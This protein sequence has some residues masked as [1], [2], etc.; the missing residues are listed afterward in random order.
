MKKKAMGGA[1]AWPLAFMGIVLFMFLH[2][3]LTLAFFTKTEITGN[4]PV[5][6][7]GSS[8]DLVSNSKF[9]SFLGTEIF[10]NGKNQ[11]IIE[12][13]RVTWEP[14]SNIK[15]KKGQS[16]TEVFN[17]KTLAS[18]VQNPTTD[19]KYLMTVKYGFTE[20]DYYELYDI[21][22][23]INEG[24]FVDK[25]IN[26]L[27]KLCDIDKI[28]KYYLETPYGVITRDGMKK[29]DSRIDDLFDESGQSDS[30]YT[31]FISH[32]TNYKGENIEIRF[33]MLK[34]CQL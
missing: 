22:K 16:L 12:V 34:A 32:K 25:I 5:T 10:V 2:V 15:N 30:E 17:F 13:L 7:E 8:V 11:K 29:K 4:V 31:P 27:N 19:F 20:D 28:D 1:V 26:E 6:F 3:S 21:N 9:L 14:Y 18:E 23:K 33:I 24:K